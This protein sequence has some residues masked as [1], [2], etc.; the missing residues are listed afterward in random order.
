VSG[1]E[2][3]PRPILRFLGVENCPIK[4]KHHT[5]TTHG[6]SMAL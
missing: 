2:F 4:I 6:F 1:P 5:G 3:S